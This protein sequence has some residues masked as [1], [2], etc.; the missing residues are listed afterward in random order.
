MPLAV[1]LERFPGFEIFGI[2]EIFK[3]AQGCQSFRWFRNE[4][5]FVGLSR[6]MGKMWERTELPAREDE[7]LHFRFPPGNFVVSLLRSM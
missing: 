5:E 3:M 7:E 2:F 1:R 6:V 4:R